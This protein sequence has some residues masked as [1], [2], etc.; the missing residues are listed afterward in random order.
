MIRFSAKSDKGRQLIAIGLSEGNVQR[1]Q[2]GFPIHVHCDDMGFAGEIMIFTGKD[3]VS[4]TNMLIN[5]G[6]DIGEVMDTSKQ[7]K[8]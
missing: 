5:A 4:M 3:E 6:L 8:N 7:P 2:A 1:M